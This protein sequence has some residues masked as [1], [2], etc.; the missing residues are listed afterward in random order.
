M[1]D[2]WLPTPRLLPY[3]CHR[4]GQDSADS[5]PYFEENFVF[6][7]AGAYD[8]RELTLY[9]SARW[10]EQMC[11][12]PGS[13][14]DVMPKGEAQ[15]MQKHIEVLEADREA[16][17]ARIAEL[18]ANVVDPVPGGCSCSP[19]ADELVSALVERLDA[20]YSRKPGRK[21]AAKS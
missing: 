9:H 19:D 17:R 12:A 2:S 13:P 1:S 7:E 11:D 20:R 4:T 21:P 8:D 10:F 5:G 14:F 16:L 3:R 15:R 18:E 6:A